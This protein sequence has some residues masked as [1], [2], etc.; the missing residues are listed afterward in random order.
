MVYLRK[1]YPSNFNFPSKCQNYF[2]KFKMNYEIRY[3][4]EPASTDHTLKVE[5]ILIYGGYMQF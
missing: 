1:F 2:I 5:I 3:L 4:S